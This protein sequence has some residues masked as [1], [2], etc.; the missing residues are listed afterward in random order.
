[1]DEEYT[2]EPEKG[3]LHHYREVKVDEEDLIEDVTFLK[4]ANEVISNIDQVMNQSRYS[5]FK[6]SHE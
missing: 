1:M 3:L 2:V 6:R 5:S 4:V